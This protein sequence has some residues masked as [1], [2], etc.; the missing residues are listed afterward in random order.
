MTD[1]HDLLTE[2]HDTVVVPSPN[3]GDLQRR[4]TRL[5]RR[6]RLARAGAAATAS[7]FAVAAIA[8]SS[9][10][11]K[12]SAETSVAALPANPMGV[13]VILDG[14]LALIDVDGNTVDT[15][16]AGALLGVYRDRPVVLAG[17]QLVGHDD[18][19]IATS[20]RAAFV[21]ASGVT[22]QR[23]DG[24]LGVFGD[25]QVFYI[26]NCTS[27][28][29]SGSAGSPDTEVPTDGV[30]VGAGEKAY[31]VQRA[32]GL[33]VVDAAGVH[34]ISLTSDGARAEVSSVQVGG[35]TVSVASDGTVQFF[36]TEGT[37]R[38]GFLGGVVGALSADGTTYAYAPTVDELA[39]GMKPGLN[40]Y[41][42]TT[43]KLRRTSL[44]GA[45]DSI[46]W[47][48]GDLLLVTDQGAE[49]TLWRCKTR[50]CE[51]LLN[52]PGNSL[53]LR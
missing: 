19:P 29:D 14:R 44:D 11:D 25:H 10:W 8:M 2:I 53:T 39:N 1:I 15:G 22:F 24:T 48:G 3:H 21:D 42:T 38:S 50:G 33:V 52:A 5:R 43:G 49:R 35:D 7:A 32:S 41:D 28:H 16:V 17:D 9:Q 4:V 27:C 51:N 37:R 23:E 34:P 30:L 36:D 47:R 18:A 20:V 26:T 40:F 13:P 45:V 46:V 6:R 12:P 31:V